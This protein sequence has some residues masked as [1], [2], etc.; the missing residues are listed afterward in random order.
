MGRR[1]S[2]NAQ[3]QEAIALAQAGQRVEARRLLEA[4]VEADPRQ[5]TAWMW[6]ATVAGDRDERLR[7]L[8][9]AL[10]LNPSNP[11]T[12]Q[13]YRQLTGDD[14]APEPA[15]DTPPGRGWRAHLTQDAPISLPFVLVLMVLAAGA[16]IA[17]VVI[18]NNRSDDGQGSSRPTLTPVFILPTAT[19]T[20]GPPPT[21]TRTPFPTYTL[22]PSPTSIW[23]APPATWTVEPT[24]TIPP[25]R[26]LLP[27]LTPIP[28]RTITPSP[29]PATAT[30]TP[31]PDSPTL[32]GV[33]TL[34]PAATR[35]RQ[36]LTQTAAAEL[37]LSA[38][39]PTTAPT[40]T[41]E[42][43]EINFN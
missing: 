18:A 8:R 14:Y 10:A 35:D 4:I 6:L 29:A 13:A 5:E 20:F 30:D 24:L 37:T 2:L 9:R 40:A 22:G 27:S 23:L 12:A 36:R 1:E 41:P 21:I 43:T 28:T 16:V 15:G 39:P 31:G 3:L 19:A 25:S 17:I 11:T 7:F 42:A 38:P 26:T 32:S 34:T 33:A